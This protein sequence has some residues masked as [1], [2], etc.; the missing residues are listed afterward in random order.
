MIGSPAATTR[1]VRSWHLATCL[2]LANLQ[3][4][5]NAT[6][7]EGYTE[8]LRTIEVASDESGTVAE[9]LVKPGDAV[10]PGQ[11]LIRLDSQVHEAQLAIA[12]QQMSS[13]GYLDAAKAE[14]ELARERWHR[15]QSLHTTGHARQSELSRAEKELKVAEAN[16]RTATEDLETRRLEYERI[17]TQLK[18]R[19]IHAPVAGVV[20]ELHKEAGE[21][22]AP[23]R[24]EVLTLVQLDSL[25]ANFTVMP[26]QAATLKEGQTITVRFIETR[27]ASQ[28]TVSFVSPVTDAESGS[29]L[30][31]IRLDNTD[32]RY[33]S[34][35]RCRIRLED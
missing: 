3:T 34:G 33:R 17:A 25:L 19:S 7:L 15:L 6:E 30:V 35:Q 11:P 13:S 1:L 10:E 26:F 29:V 31:Q 22:V 18:R 21:F 32:R 16:V 20:T 2:V 24:P 9:V 5:V 23:N 12:K 28:G 8:P 27:Q 14:L 4:G